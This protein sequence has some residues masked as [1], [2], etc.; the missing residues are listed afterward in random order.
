MFL[1]VWTQAEQ[2]SNLF[3]T[4]TDI[5]VSERIYLPCCH[6][7]VAH[8][9]NFIT[10]KIRSFWTHRLYSNPSTHEDVTPLQR[11]PQFRIFSQKVFLGFL[12]QERSE[13]KFKKQSIA[14]LAGF[15]FTI[16]CTKSRSAMRYPTFAVKKA[17]TQFQQLFNDEKA[18]EWKRH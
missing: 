12:W 11:Q 10:C 2:I 14:A 16:F 6:T 15:L 3:N 8:V 9:P 1:V 4:R 7:W 5:T 17:S 18:F 13:I